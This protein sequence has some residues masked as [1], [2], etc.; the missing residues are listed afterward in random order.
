MAN[1]R[2]DVTDFGSRT[3][4]TFENVSGPHSLTVTFRPV[5]AASSSGSSSSDKEFVFVFDIPLLRPAVRRL[6]R[7]HCA[8]FSASSDST[9]APTQNKNGKVP[10]ILLIVIALLV[11]AIAAVIIVMAVRK[12]NR[13][14]GMRNTK[15]IAM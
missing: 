3:S 12:R 2:V 6:F 5:K 15:S 13:I 14:P 9:T 1:V 10:T 4:Y 7:Q 11:A 8:Q